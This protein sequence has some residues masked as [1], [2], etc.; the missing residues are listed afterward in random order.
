MDSR[1]TDSAPSLS[2]M[3][4]RRVGGVA[5]GEHQP[6]RAAFAV[7]GEVDLA[8]HT[9]SGAADRMV[10]RLGIAAANEGIRVVRS[11]PLCPC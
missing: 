2:K 11:S 5:A 8:G 10:K 3:A 1:Q 6:Q 9:A 7:G 4:V